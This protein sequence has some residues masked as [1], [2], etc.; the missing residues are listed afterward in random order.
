MIVL[1]SYENHLLA[2]FEK[3]YKKK[4]IITFYF[5][6]HSLHF[7]QLL[8]VGCFNILK[9]LYGWRFEDLIKTY[10]NHIIKIEFFIEFKAAHL[11]TMTS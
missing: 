6:M 2:R 5:F 11:N 10:I 1:N 4:N 9:R 7:I 3:F 8:D